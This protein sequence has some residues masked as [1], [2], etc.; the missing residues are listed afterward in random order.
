[1]EMENFGVQGSSG[2]VVKDTVVK[3]TPSDTPLVPS[4]PWPPHLPSFVRVAS[5][6]FP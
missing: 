6:K 4:P 2:T 5:S 1:M 3:V